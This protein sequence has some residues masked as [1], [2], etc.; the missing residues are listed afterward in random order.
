MRVRH[1]EFTSKQVP[2]VVDVSY[3]CNLPA[4]LKNLKPK[5]EVRNPAGEKSSRTKFSS[6]FSFRESCGAEYLGGA[7]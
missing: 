2:K 3:V 7:S 4:I 1:S 5:S 6:P